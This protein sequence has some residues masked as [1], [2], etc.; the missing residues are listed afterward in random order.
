MSTSSW[1]EAEEGEILA[2]MQVT[3]PGEDSGEG[4]GA[5]GGPEW[6]ALRFIRRPLEARADVLR[7]D[8]GAERPRARATTSRPP[9]PAARRRP[10]Q[11]VPPEEQGR[12]RPRPSP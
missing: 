4:R 3:S 11:P 9:A 8:A 12:V 6:N 2:R 7:G 1:V 5:G 10:P